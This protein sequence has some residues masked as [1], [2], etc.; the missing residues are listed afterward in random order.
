MHICKRT[1]KV[2]VFIKYPTACVKSWTVTWHNSSTC[3]MSSSSNENAILGFSGVPGQYRHL[4][5]VIAFPSH[6]Q[7][8]NSI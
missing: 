8:G 7:K 6:G 1:L 4:I 2:L 5:K 3:N